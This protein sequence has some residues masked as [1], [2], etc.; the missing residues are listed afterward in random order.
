M[1]PFYTEWKAKL[2]CRYSGLTLCAL[3]GRH[4]QRQHKSS[5]TRVTCSLAMERIVTGSQAVTTYRMRFRRG[6]IGFW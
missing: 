3:Q 5:K 6:S 2:T 4:N 1:D